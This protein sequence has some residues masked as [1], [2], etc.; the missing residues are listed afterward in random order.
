MSSCLKGVSLTFFL[1]KNS[2]LEKALYM[3][4]LRCRDTFFQQFAVQI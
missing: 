2:V 1:N 3:T 4:D